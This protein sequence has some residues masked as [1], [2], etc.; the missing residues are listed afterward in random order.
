[1]DMAGLWLHVCLQMIPFLAESEGKL[2]RVVDE[3][4]NV[5]GRGKPK[6]NVEKSKVT[7]FKRKEV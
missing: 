6:V 7:D 4:C 3:F 5:P 1:M 2:Q